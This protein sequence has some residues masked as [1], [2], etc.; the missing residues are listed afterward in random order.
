MARSAR[1]RLGELRR[2]A[3]VTPPPEPEPA[4]PSHRAGETFQDCANCPEM[5]VLPA[6]SFQMGSPSGE[7]GRDGDEGPLH[8]VSVEQAFAVGK[9]EVTRGQYAAFVRATGRGSGGGCYVYNGSEWGAQSSRSW[10]DPGY[11]QNDRE[12]VV[13]V[14]W[15]D[16]EA[17]VGWLS[18]ETGHEYRLLAEAEWEYAARA[19]TRTARYWGASADQACGYANVHD[20]TS[21]RENGFDWEHHDCDDGYGQTAPVGSFAPNAFGLYDMLGN[22]WEWT[23]DCWHD[24]YSGAPTHSIA[25]QG[26]SD[27]RR[28]LRGGSWGGNPRGVRAAYRYGDD[29]GD[30]NFNFGFRVAR[31]LY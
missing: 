6:G 16:A 26:S 24:N 12:P 7:E 31:T 30:R 1:D 25:W 9:H 4:P 27:C 15:N 11:S 19:G 23:Q 28:V 13:C 17:Y 10:R 29:T 5:V 22:V 8:R 21:N 14:N 3:V 18:R 20:R 2:V